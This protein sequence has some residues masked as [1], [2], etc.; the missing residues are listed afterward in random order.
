MADTYNFLLTTIGRRTYLVKYFQK[1][2]QNKGK[3]YVTNSSPL[4]PAFEVADGAFV[5]PLTYDE[6]YIPFILK[7]CKE[8]GIKA[9]VPVFDLELPFLAKA[10][11]AFEQIGVQIVVS[12]EHVVRICNDKWLSYIF[13]RDHNIQTPRTYLDL[14]DL[15]R[16]I[17]EK[18]VSFPIMIKP[19][20][21]MGTMATY[22]ADN[23]E[24]LEILYK[25][26]K[27]EIFESYLKYEAN[28]DSDNCV[29]LQ[30]KVSGDEYGL[31]IICDLK[32]KY[33][34]TIVKKKYEMRANETDC[35]LTVKDSRLESIGRS[36]AESFSGIRGLMD[37]DII[38]ADGIDYIL[39]LNARF[40]GGY[41]F[42]HA[43]GADIPMAI[44]KWIEGET[45]EE[46]L[47]TAREGVMSRK[48]ISIA[49]LNGGFK[50]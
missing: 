41:P 28:Q 24:E 6:E 43:A 4:V 9:I 34:H 26:C 29:I 5:A 19:R 50:E 10:K 27:K 30:E 36:I 15:K 49:L 40:G 11:P 44:V 38:R 20:W 16:A 33:T 46:A 47:F 25:K 7:I 8:N 45:T 37:V 17:K 14:S 21:G 13:L 1:A 39:D 2:L 12:E 3:V 22:E 18:Q 48:E 23:T 31:D 32:C 42:S 35:A